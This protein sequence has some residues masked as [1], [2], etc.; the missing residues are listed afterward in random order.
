MNYAQKFSDMA[1]KPN[2]DMETFANAMLNHS[3]LKARD[4]KSAL[5]RELYSS[6]LYLKKGGV[7][8]VD[9]HAHIVNMAR[10]LIILQFRRE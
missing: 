9:V 2:K 5:S 3:Q 4:Q 1:A 6:P 8:P 7:H 10:H